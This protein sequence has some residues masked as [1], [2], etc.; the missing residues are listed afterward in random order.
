MKKP[1]A[2]QPP[3][4]GFETRPKRVSDRIVA[5]RERRSKQVDTSQKPLAPRAPPKKRSGV[6]QKPA[7]PKKAVPESKQT[8]GRKRTAPKPLK[9]PRA[10]KAQLPPLVLEALQEHEERT[11]NDPLPPDLTKVHTRIS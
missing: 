5:Q 6:T 11:A 3:S 10:R 9:L 8:S 1:Q 2:R 7:G 4:D